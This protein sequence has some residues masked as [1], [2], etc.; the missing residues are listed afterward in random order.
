LEDLQERLKDQKV[1]QL[2]QNNKEALIQALEAEI[3]RMQQM[4]EEQKLS[5]LGG[6]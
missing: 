1:A 4:V 3:V 5:S 2:F 6:E